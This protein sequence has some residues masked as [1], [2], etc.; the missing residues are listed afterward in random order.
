MES[1]VTLGMLTAPL[2]AARKARSTF[3]AVTDR[4]AILWDA[5]WWGAVTVRSFR[6]DAPPVLAQVDENRPARE[7]RGHAG[8]RER[9]SPGG[10]QLL[11]D[12]HL[13][14]SSTSW[15]LGMPLFG[16]GGRGDRCRSA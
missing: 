6:A 7:D 16:V 5:G 4:R 3:Y 15:A 9:T 8:D 13:N 12:L 2:W 14:A 10:R 1:C 11:S